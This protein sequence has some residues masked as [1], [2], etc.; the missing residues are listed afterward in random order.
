MTERILDC[1]LPLE[2]HLIGEDFTNEETGQERAGSVLIN[3][4]EP[5]SLRG[6]HSLDA[7]LL[8]ALRGNHL[9][10]ADP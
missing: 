6:I 7:A 8:D 10:L 1:Q 3:Q 5:P 9:Y 4:M 2:I